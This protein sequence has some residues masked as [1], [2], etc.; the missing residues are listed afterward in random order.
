MMEFYQAYATYED[1]MTMTEEMFTALSERIFGSQNFTYQGTE[2]DLARPWQ[3][4]T[5]KEAIIEHCGI[6]AD[7]LEDV[8]KATA[9][10][11]KLGIDVPEGTPLG[12]VMMEIFDEKVEDRIIQPTFITQ[13]PLE[14]SPL[15]RKN[16]QDPGFYGSV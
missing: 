3:R 7:V 12:K 14:V 2:I 9:F 6:E 1:L 11:R 16:E 8:A 13:Y 4:M 15:A 5:V 10:A